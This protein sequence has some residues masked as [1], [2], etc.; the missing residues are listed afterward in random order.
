MQS[1]QRLLGGAVFQCVGH[2][3][4]LGDPS[5][6]FVR[7]VCVLVVCVWLVQSDGLGSGTGF[8]LMRCRWLQHC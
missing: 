5:L 1:V 4:L 8:R 6:L 2:V 7:Q 3:Q